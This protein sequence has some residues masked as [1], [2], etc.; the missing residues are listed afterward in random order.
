MKVVHLGIG[1]VPVPPG[2]RAAGREEYIYQ[3]TRHLGQ[4][5]CQVHVIDIK[6]GAQ[7]EEKRQEFGES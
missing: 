1:L 6:G 2:D 7:Q 4:Q 3:L 5:G